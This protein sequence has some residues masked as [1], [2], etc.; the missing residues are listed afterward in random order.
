MSIYERSTDPNPS[1]DPV[2]EPGRTPGDKVPEVI[3]PPDPRRHDQPGPDS[4]HR[5]EDIPAQKVRFANPCV[6]RAAQ[7]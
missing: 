1:R 7:P 3:D 4:P 6:S 5:P 2:R